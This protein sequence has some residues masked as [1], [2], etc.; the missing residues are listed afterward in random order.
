MAIR[1]EFLGI[2]YGMLLLLGM[3]AI[4][5]VAIFILGFVLFYKTPD[6]VILV[7]WLYAAFGF[8]LIQLLYVIPVV[9]RLKK[10]Q[11]WGMM[12]GVI[13]GAVITALV[14]GGCFL[15]YGRATF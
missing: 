9:L 15:I 14:N 13:I 2:I 4:A 6:Y 7:F 3:H 5:I 12:K 1:N 11:R 8:S 10:Q